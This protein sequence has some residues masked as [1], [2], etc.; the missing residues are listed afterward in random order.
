MYI[1]YIYIYIYMI[2]FNY[3]Y[4]VCFDYNFAFNFD[5]FS[6]SY[7][8]DLIRIK[9]HVSSFSSFNLLCSGFHILLLFM[10]TIDA[11]EDY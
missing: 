9:R 3:L 7:L 2:L 1:I 4:F 8:L 10:I 5:A 11:E 6:S